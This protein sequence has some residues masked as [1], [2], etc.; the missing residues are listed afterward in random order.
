MTTEKVASEAAWLIAFPSVERARVLAH[1]IH[2]LT[3]AG[4]CLYLSNGDVL[5][6]LERLRELNEVQHRVAGYLQHALTDSEDP[7]WIPIVVGFILGPRDSEV[8]QQCHL[9]WESVRRYSGVA[10]RAG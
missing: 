10:G 5:T 3:V 9:A 7:G 6:R 4:R 8:R 1:L 2:D